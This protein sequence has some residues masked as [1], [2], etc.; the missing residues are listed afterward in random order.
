MKSMQNKIFLIWILICLFAINIAFSESTQKKTIC[1]NMIVKNERD[2]IERCLES[3]LPLIDYWIIVDT[4]SSDGTQDIIKKY[5]QNK[6]IPGELHERP[7]VDFAHNRN[8]ALQFAKGKGD[9]LL[10]I[11]ADDVLAFDP[12]FKLPF[13]DK[14]F[15]YL[16]MSFF[17]SRYGLVRL[18]NNHLLWKWEGVRHETLICSNA[19]TSDYLKNVLN[20]CS[21]DGARS[22]NP[23]KYKTDAEALEVALEK[24]PHNTR[25]VFY[26]AQS[27]RDSLQYNKALKMYQ[28][29][30]TMGG[31]DQEIFYSLYQIGV[32]KEV[33]NFSSDEVINAY[34]EAFKARPLRIEPLYRLARYH[35]IQGNYDDG[36]KLAK[37]ISEMPFFNDLLFVEK[38]L[39]D[40]GIK[41]ELSIC[42][43]W[44]GKYDECKHLCSM[45]ANMN[46][47]PEEIKIANF[48]N[49]QFAISKIIEQMYKQKP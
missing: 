3:V 4:G 28:K 1:L 16:T 12:E 22:K 25:I 49:L 27:Y 38:W 23:D 18:V 39:Y 46:D 48:R 19:K 6:N 33:L 2:V 17:G 40:Y 8:Q 13:L 43:Y 14:D 45:L 26:L 15:Y 24:E 30:V 5:M 34:L 42:A 44:I 29:R 20:V 41:F 9:Y 7:W 32:L 47:I 36:Y 35:R 21:T 31:W 37:I 10:F 11:D